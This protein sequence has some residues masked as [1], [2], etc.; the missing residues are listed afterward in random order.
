MNYRHLHNISTKKALVL[1]KDGLEGLKNRLDVL[2]K[3]KLKIYERLHSIDPKEKV[4]HLLSVDEV[5]ELENAE[6]ELAKITEIL[7][8]AT[9]VTRRKKSGKIGVGSTVRLYS[10]PRYVEYTIVSSLEADPLSNKISNDSPLGKILMGKKVG[11]S[12]SFITRKGKE[13]T[14]NIVE[15]K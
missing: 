2:M 7:R 10:F 8:Y 13:S 9:P 4:D 12:V 1:T 5:R 6:A 3:E 14:Y 11:Q 15:L